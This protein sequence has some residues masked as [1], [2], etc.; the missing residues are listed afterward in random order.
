MKGH[1]C[2][3]VNSLITTLSTHD[4]YQRRRSFAVP[5][6]VRVRPA[7][8]VF[9][10]AGRQPTVRAPDGRPRFPITSAASTW[11]RY[12]TDP[13]LPPEPGGSFQFASTLPHRFLNE[14][15]V[16]SVVPWAVTPP[17]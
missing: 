6:Q 2:L 11:R 5:R 15:S 10:L 14:G 13:L 3:A 17:L 4:K 7:A 1:S 8:A 9:V 16:R 12:N